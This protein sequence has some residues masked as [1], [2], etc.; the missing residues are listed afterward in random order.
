MTNITAKKDQNNRG[1]D[2]IN[3]Q[4]RSIWLTVDFI[5]ITLN[6]NTNLDLIELNKLLEDKT[7]SILNNDSVAKEDL[8][9]EVIGNFVLVFGL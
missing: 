9:M 5:N 1:E 2:R 3:R 8:L 6:I 7:I 4:L